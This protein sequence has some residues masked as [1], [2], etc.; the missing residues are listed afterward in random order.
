VVFNA[1]SLEKFGPTVVPGGTIIYDTSVISSVPKLDE[2]VRVVGVP[3]AE[4]A[5]DLGNLKV[6]NIVA[7]GALQAATELFPED[8]FLAA[9][10]KALRSKPDLLPLNEQAYARGAEAARAAGNGK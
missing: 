7:M 3:Y 4:I 8:S 9:M 6:K 5:Q 2:S 1:P 10:R